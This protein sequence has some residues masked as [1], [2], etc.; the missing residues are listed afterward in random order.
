MITHNYF[1]RGHSQMEGDSVHATIETS[2]K[3]L[4][5]YSPSDWITAIKNAKRVD[6]RYA[7]KEI[8]SEMILNF[9]EFAEKIVTNRKTDDE[10]ESVVWTSV[11]SF[12]YKKR[13][14]QTNYILN[15]TMMTHTEPL[16]FYV[17]DVKVKV[18]EV[19]R[20]IN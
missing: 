17:E 3:K 6:P 14:N 4:E 8:K 9:K 13:T 7:V 15:T 19:L 1:E 12:Q 18:Q 2:T 16:Q 20:D 10:G 5:I 11:H